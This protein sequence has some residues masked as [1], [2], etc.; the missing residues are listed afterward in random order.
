MGRS[1][2]GGSALVM[3]AAI[4]GMH[5]TGMAA[6]TFVPTGEEATPS[7]DVNTLGMGLGTESSPW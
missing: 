1:A 2:Y 7:Y 3:G 6:A 5:Y 4:T